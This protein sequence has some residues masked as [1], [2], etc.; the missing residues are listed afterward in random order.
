MACPEGRRSARGVALGAGGTGSSDRPPARRTIWFNG[1]AGGQYRRE[2]APHHGEGV[3]VDSCPA[4]AQRDYIATGQLWVADIDD[5]HTVSRW[6]YA[7]F[8]T[9]VS[10][11]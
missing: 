9:D 11:A 4:L 10:W 6:I 8:V 2:W 5:C 7:V 3:E 1:W